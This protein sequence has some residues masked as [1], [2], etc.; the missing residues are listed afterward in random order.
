MFAALFAR[1]PGTD[2]RDY[3]DAE[4]LIA[5]LT[6]YDQADITGS[7][8]G[9]H[10][11]VAQ[12]ITWNTAQSRHES[13][14]ERCAETGRIIAS[15]IRLD[16]RAELC[17]ALRLEDRAELTD[18]QIVLAAHRAW[19]E[20]CAD[21]LEGDFAFAIHDPA[22]RTTFCARDAAGAKP[23][24]YHCSDALFVCASTAAIFP[25][26]SRLGIGPC[27]RWM[28]R[29]LEGIS[30]DTERT[31]FEGVV[32]LPPGHRITVG[33]DTPPS[34]ERYFRFEDTAPFATTRDERWVRDYREMFHRAVEDRLRSA[35]RIGA[36]SSGGLDSSTIVAHAAEHVWHGK[37]DMH[38]FGLA[39]MEQEPR[40][41]LE[42]ASHCGLSKNHILTSP[43]YFRDRAIV[44]RAVDALGYPPE[45]GLASLY[46]WF[47]EECALHG[48]RT[49]LSGFGG[50]EAVTGSANG[51]R[52]EL[53]VNGAYLAAFREPPGGVLQRGRRLA[54]IATALRRG[55]PGVSAASE[56]M[57]GERLKHSLL[58]KDI[59][60]E[61]GIAELLHQANR[62]Q[63]DPAQSIN[64]RVLQRFEQPFWNGAIAGRLEGC[65]LMANTWRVDYRWPLLDRRL[66]AQYLATPG[67]EKRKGSMGRYLHRRACAGTIPESILWRQSKSLGAIGNFTRL[68]QM[69]GGS[70]YDPG[71]LAEPLAELVDR[72][73][74]EQAFALCSQA[75]TAENGPARDAARHYGRSM[76]LIGDL[77]I[78]IAAQQ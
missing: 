24:F 65:Q 64:E 56:A 53:V 60:R 11:L 2:P 48:V 58:S 75:Q 18:P 20:E 5:A 78:F 74:V 54:G 13:A 32:K 66:I 35:Y 43:P 22:T 67:I 27:R 63:D 28:A 3:T 70:E 38:C 68:A 34:P 23:F 6:P 59:Q 57:V 16:N 39:H 15:W 17:A 26:I 25:R 29:Y 40:Y 55:E 69:P 71:A 36:E 45:N 49:L 9:D 46:H 10:A 37:D 42:T 76:R 31:A 51:L 1:R 41:V 77:S 30:Y 7:W 47:F 21:R 61:F 8:T 73:R 4:A 33:P 52:R 72:H 12:A 50:D 14:P 44:R 19:G 62:E